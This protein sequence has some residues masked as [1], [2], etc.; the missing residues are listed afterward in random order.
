MHDKATILAIFFLLSQFVSFAH[1]GGIWVRGK[2]LQA[3]SSKTYLRPCNCIFIFAWG[4]PSRTVP[5]D[6]EFKHKTHTS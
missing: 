4:R 6:A 2:E 1:I 5:L 3:L